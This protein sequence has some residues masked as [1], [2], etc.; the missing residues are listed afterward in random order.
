MSYS[1]RN[2]K[3]RHKK[4]LKDESSCLNVSAMAMNSIELSYVC[5]DCISDSYLSR[6]IKAEYGVALCLGCGNKK[7][8]SIGL[9][10]LSNQTHKVIETY[11]DLTIDHPEGYE[12]I[13]EREGLWER[14]GS[15]ID[16]VIQDIIGVS[17][18]VSEAIVEYLSNCH[19]SKGKDAYYTPQPYDNEAYYE[20]RSS[21]NIEFHESWLSVKSSVSREARFFNDY[22]KE[23]LDHIFKG[24][25][26]AFTAERKTVIRTITTNTNFYRSRVAKS[27]SELE[28]ILKELPTSIGPPGEAFRRSGRMNAH[29]ISVFYGALDKD[30]CLAEVRAPVGA[31]VVTGL[32]NPLKDLK[33]LDLSRFE[34]VGVKDGSYFDDEHMTDIGR[35]IF[36]KYLTME[37]SA[38]I[39]PGDEEKQYVATQVVADY[40]ATN[41][42]LKLDGLIFNSSQVDISESSSSKD[43]GKNVVLFYNASRLN[44]QDYPDGKDF[45]LDLGWE[46]DG[47]S[48]LSLTLRETPAV[49]ED[50]LVDLVNL[51]DFIEPTISLLMDSVEVDYIKGVSVSLES[52]NFRRY[53]FTN[54]KFD[55]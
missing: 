33:I 54:D 51:V 10:E 42:K 50:G 41:S 17:N 30:T 45:D 29:G 22:A 27:Q 46:D 3:K 13:L 47:D 16:Q 35:R 38:P 24:V 8:S 6:K 39:M 34:S 7:N 40:L 1:K 19:D 49:E 28:C 26:S 55:F 18:S 11:F 14:S 37:L 31:T 53:K 25:D 48:D 15:E 52:R 21:D 12:C 5:C 32:F 20:E 4:L 44:N 2:R 23:M 43:I 36:L 9:E